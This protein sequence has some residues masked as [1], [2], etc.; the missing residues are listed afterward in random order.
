M[1]RCSDKLGACSMKWG[2]E[3]YNIHGTNNMFYGFI[4][5]SF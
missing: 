1:R 4:F 3:I 5:A 2:L